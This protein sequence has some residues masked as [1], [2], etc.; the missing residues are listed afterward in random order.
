MVDLR[1]YDT[2]FA[3]QRLMPG[4]MTKILFDRLAHLL[5]AGAQAIPESAQVR[6]ALFD[7]RPVVAPGRA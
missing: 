5:H 3:K 7:G 1:E 6:T 4:A 2:P